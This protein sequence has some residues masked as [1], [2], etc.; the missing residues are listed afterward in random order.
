MVE[1]ACKSVV[2]FRF[3]QS[4]MH[5]S[6]NGFLRLLHLR[7]CILNGDWDAFARSHYPRLRNL[8]AAYF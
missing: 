1:A 6:E 7:L 5:W 3:K 4:G 2:A 8:P